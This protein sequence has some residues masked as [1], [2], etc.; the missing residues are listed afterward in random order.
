M[1]FVQERSLQPNPVADTGCEYSPS[2]FTCPLPICKYD[3]R[4]KSEMLVLRN[5]R[6]REMRSRGIEVLDIAAAVDVSP[7][8][9]HRVMRGQSTRGSDPDIPNGPPLRSVESLR[10]LIRAR[11]PN[12]PMIG[13]SK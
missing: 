1:K 3:E 10:P 6:I 12:P 8:T 9:V 11:P 7:R 2:C 5:D 13:A 4:P